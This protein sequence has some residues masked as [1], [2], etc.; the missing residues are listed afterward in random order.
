MT[1]N[2]NY[3]T[4]LTKE[5]LMDAL[6]LLI[7]DIV[8]AHMAEI[9]DGIDQMIDDRLEMAGESTVDISDHVDE[10]SDIVTDVLSNATI[11][12]SAN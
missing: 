2:G 9:M 1:D 12:I 7:G 8:K 4:I 5:V 11:T 6:V 3:G 10:I